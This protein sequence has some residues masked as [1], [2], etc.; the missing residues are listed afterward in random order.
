MEHVRHAG[1]PATPI[2]SPSIN[3]LR[4][5]ENPAPGDFLYFVTIDK[6]GTTLF[7]RSYEE[8]L[9]NIELAQKSGIL[10]SGR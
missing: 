2:A 6:K 10:D 8:H 7:T 1:L 9:A 3:A 4:A 5:V